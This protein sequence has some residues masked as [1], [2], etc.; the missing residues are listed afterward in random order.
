MIQ[1]QKNIMLRNYFIK[2]QYSTFWQSAFWIIFICML[3]LTL[4]PRLPQVASSIPHMDKLFHFIA[5]SGFS[6]VFSIAFNKVKITKVI[7]ISISIGVGIEI[8]QHFIPNRG[9]SYLDMLADGLG[10]LN[11]ILIAKQIKFC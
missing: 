3:V 1:Y 2:K 9:F 7:F 8:A 10:V 5:F 4:S 11:G 6:F